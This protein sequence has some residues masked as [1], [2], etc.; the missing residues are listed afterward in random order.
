MVYSDNQKLI[1]ERRKE[2]VRQSKDRE[3]ERESKMSAAAS[4][5]NSNKSPSINKRSVMDYQSNLWRTSFAERVMKMSTEEFV[6]EIK[7]NSPEKNFYLYME[8]P[9]TRKHFDDMQHRC[10]CSPSP[11]KSE[12]GYS[13]TSRKGKQ[14]V[15]SSLKKKKLLRAPSNYSRS[16]KGIPEYRV[17]CR[18]SCSTIHHPR[19]HLNRG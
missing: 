3:K 5:K 10:D 8:K 14:H 12:M 1:H 6:E 2:F 18:K 7:E 4:N 19:F 11:R 9:E 16:S 13:S 15:C 17:C